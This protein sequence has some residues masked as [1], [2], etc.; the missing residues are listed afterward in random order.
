[1]ATKYFCDGC[2]DEV[3]EN[4]TFIVTIATPQQLMEAERHAAMGGVAPANRS[5]SYHVCPSCENELRRQADPTT[6]ARPVRAA[7]S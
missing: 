4:R 7:A 2:D 3:A 5:K 6:W 1:M